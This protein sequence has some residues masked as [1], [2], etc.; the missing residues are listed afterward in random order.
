[1]ETITIEKVIKF[2]SIIDSIDNV[3]VNDELRY[4]LSEENTHANGLILI[5]G[6]V[7]TLTGKKDFNEEVDVDIYAPFEKELD[8]DNFK[9]TVKDYSYVVSNKNL[10]MYLVLQIQGIKD[11]I[12]KENNELVEEMNTLNEINDESTNKRVVEEVKVIE[13]VKEV[14]KQKVNIKESETKEEITKSWSNDL[15]KLDNSYVIFHKFKSK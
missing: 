7:N 3:S 9:I 13:E 14:N 2:D 15:F 8:K 12:S 10:I 6:S 11:A 1:M 5:S 4:E